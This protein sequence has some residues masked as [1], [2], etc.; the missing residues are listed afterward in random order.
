M[1]EERKRVQELESNYE[2]VWDSVDDD[3][4]ESEKRR[5]L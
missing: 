3:E 1:T 2:Q 5:L 4:E